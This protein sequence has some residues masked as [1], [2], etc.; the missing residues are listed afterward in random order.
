[1]SMYRVMGVLSLVFLSIAVFCVLVFRVDSSVLVF[2]IVSLV[3]LFQIS[4]MLEVKDR[5]G[6]IS[7]RVFILNPIFYINLILII[8]FF[9]P[10][11]FYLLSPNSFFE[12]VSLDG[13]AVP[14]G[15][16][17]MA[18]VLLNLLMKYVDDRYVRRNV[19][20]LP[21]SRLLGKL[22]EY[23]PM[24]ILLYMVSW[25][26]K[27]FFA[28]SGLYNLG[29]YYGDVNSVRSAYPLLLP[30]F[31]LFSQ[32]IY[33]P[34]FFL[35]WM[36]YLLNK[37]KSNAYIG[38]MLTLLLA[39]D[40]LYFLPV[41]TKQGIL[42]PI[43]ASVLAI[44]ILI[45]RVPWKIMGVVCLLVLLGLPL[46]NIYRSAQGS[47]DVQTFKSIVKNYQIGHHLG[48]Q[49][50]LYTSLEIVSKRL[51]GFGSYLYFTQNIGD[52]FL[53]GQ[54]YS[55]VISM[56]IPEHLI[57]VPEKLQDKTIHDYFREGGIIKEGEQIP[58]GAPGLWGEF[59]LNFGYVGLLIG[60]PIIGLLAMFLFKVAF[61]SLSFTG[62][63]VYLYVVFYFF[64]LA[65]SGLASLLPPII[66]V[67]AVAFTL[68]MLFNTF[69]PKR[70]A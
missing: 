30:I 23:V 38:G 35:L 68:N 51:E 43:L 37:D 21:E 39:V 13:I 67:G 20:E 33:F 40:V 34:V 60:L 63:L 3:V 70:W 66:K 9:F 24:L 7:W 62:L 61:S 46:Y 53:R 1:M 12:W 42:E 4:M 5:Y 6:G 27:M 69:K 36:V 56:L 45:R 52:R 29:L 17:A 22:K 47:L 31:R 50:Y 49:N 19:G 65:H 25:L 14:I 2:L 15:V 55:G 54:S 11:V 28:S 8:Y 58:A 32:E 26:V 59:Y 16:F 41:G 18:V 10:L 64:T 48:S 44:S 57:A